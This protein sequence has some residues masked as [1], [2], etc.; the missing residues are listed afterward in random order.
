MRERVRLVHPM[1][2]VRDGDCDCETTMP[3]EHPIYPRNHEKAKGWAEGRI[4]YVS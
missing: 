4:Q 2:A 3:L 1:A